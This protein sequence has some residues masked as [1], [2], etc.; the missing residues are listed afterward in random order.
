MAREAGSA[1]AETDHRFVRWTGSRRASCWLASRGVGAGAVVGA[2]AAAARG[3]LVRGRAARARSRTVTTTRTSVSRSPRATSP[4]LAPT[5]GSN[6][7][8]L[9]WVG[10][11]AGLRAATRRAAMV[12][13][14]F[15]PSADRPRRRDDA[16]SGLEYVKQAY[17]SWKPVVPSCTLDFGKFDTIVGAEV[18]DSQDDF[19]YTRGLLYTLAQ[20]HFHTGPPR[21]RRADPR[22][23]LGRHGCQRLE[24]TVDNNVGKTFGLR[25][26]REPERQRSPRAWLDRRARAGRH[27]SR[28]PARRHR[29]RSRRRRLLRASRRA[30]RTATSS[31]AAA[32]T[33]SRRGAT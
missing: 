19:N 14:R 25:P 2:R 33:S 18:A 21:E 15:G 23:Q 31:I 9:A 12:S 29:V 20:P 30:A 4:P 22:A 6:G 8:G 16:N 28:P 32:R 27:R 13:L 1:T 5:T 10:F 11:D 26:A 24:H 17:A 3:A 7:F